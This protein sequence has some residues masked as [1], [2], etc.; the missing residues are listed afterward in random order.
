VAEPITLN[1]G[2]LATSTGTSSVTS[3]MTLS[4]N[5]TI[6]VTGTLLTVT[7]P[8][9]GTGGLTKTGAG[10]LTLEEVNTYTGPTTVDAGVLKLGPN[11][12]I[13]N[14]SSVT[15]N[16]TLDLTQITGNVYLTSLSG[17]ASGSVVTGS[18][19][20]NSLVLTNAS[21]TFDGV[22]SGTAGLRVASGT[23]TLTGI[24]TYTGPTVV[25]PGANLIAG[26]NS[27]PGD[28]VNNGSFGF[29]QSTPGVFSHN[30][31]GTGTMNIGGTGTITLTG[32]NTQS[33]GTTLSSGASVM[34]AAVNALSGNTIESNNG[35]LG[36]A[37]GIVLS[38]LT[39]T[40]TTVTLTTD[41]YTTGAQSYNNI[42]LAPSADNLTTLQ[43]VNSNIVINGTLDATV[44]KI[45]S[46][47]INAGTGEVTL[48]DS[49][50]SIA[51]PNKLTITGS[52]IFIL[53]DIL[54]GDKQEY[55]GATSIGDGTYLGKAFVK[56]FLYDSHYQY[57][58]Y[59]QN[60][61]MK[62]VDY[63]N[64]DPRNIRTLVSQDPTI[65]FNGTVDDVSQFTHTL[66]VAAIAANAT[67]ALAASTMPVI[68]FNSSISKSIPLYSINAQTVA[69]I[70]GTNAPDL[71]RYFGQI[72]VVGDVKTFYNQVFHAGT[73][74]ATSE[75]L[76]G[77][78]VFSVYDPNASIL[79]LLAPKSD[80]SGQINLLNPG[81]QNSLLLNGSSNFRLTPNLT[82][83]DS[84]SKGFVE[85]YALNYKP[86]LV[87]VETGR[88]IMRQAKVEQL[89]FEKAV[90]GS[91]SIYGVDEKSTACSDELVD[92]QLET[93]CI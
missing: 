62:P 66:L 48:G 87:D 36:I 72:N 29:S 80:G 84:W 82:G 52:R 77:Q 86:I 26:V 49:V 75:T 70:S 27:I 79:F 22:I 34:I 43:T 14:S 88:P 19:A 18:V 25:D 32:T 69:A 91:V 2:T 71:S 54:T 7:D 31:T 30:M 33:G 53:A 90:D 3:P 41:I 6:S 38:S 24:N 11:A 17:S 93:E 78:V 16:A 23:Q 92:K 51:R 59:A 40:G 35:S 56:G 64:N 61:V 15:V 13:A 10:T 89:S 42:K 81:S 63:S 1:G 46:I 65:T 67:T 5:S 4:A 83:A 47:L 39:V 57:F 68:N 74:T 8:I 20:P 9:S 73:M 76:G 58:E 45:Q 50:G 37:D 44:S 28:I 21:G 55:N 60:G 12:S 85:G